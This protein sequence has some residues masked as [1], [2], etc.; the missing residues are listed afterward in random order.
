MDS[1]TRLS[2]NQITTERASLGETVDRCARHGV[3]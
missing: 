1:V 2:L 3:P